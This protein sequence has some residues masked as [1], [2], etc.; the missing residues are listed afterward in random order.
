MVMPMPRVIQ[1][2]TGNSRGRVTCF[3]AVVMQVE[4]QC[5]VYGVAPGLANVTNTYKIWRD[6]HRDDLTR[7]RIFSIQRSAEG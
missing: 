5:D 7:D 3:G 1:T 2:L 6:A 4:I